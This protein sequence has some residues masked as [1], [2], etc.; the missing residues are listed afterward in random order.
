MAMVDDA[1]TLKRLWPDVALELDMSQDTF[2]VV[3]TSTEGIGVLG[4]SYKNG[5][6]DTLGYER[7]S[8]GMHFTM[9][10]PP[11]VRGER[12]QSMATVD[13]DSVSLPRGH[14]FEV[15][16]KV[17]SY[18]KISTKERFCYDGPSTYSWQVE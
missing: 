5:M 7:G 8:S 6:E 14:I 2:K 1:R 10:M 9:H 15:H 4:L 11:R 16:A 12:V 3:K 13:D 17:T 18:H